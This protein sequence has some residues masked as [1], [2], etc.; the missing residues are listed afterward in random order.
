MRP[1]AGRPIPARRGKFALAALL[2][3]ALATLIGCVP[4]KQAVTTNKGLIEAQPAQP[5]TSRG[6]QYAVHRW[7]PDDSLTFLALY[8]ADD[9]A[10]GETIRAANPDLDL[11]G[12]VAS[13]TEV[14]IPAGI[15]I[16]QVR[17]SVK[18]V[19]RAEPAP[20]P[21]TTPAPKSTSGL[22]E[23]DLGGAVASAGPVLTPSYTS[24]LKTGG[25]H[26]RSAKRPLK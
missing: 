9:K 12:R 22:A 17:R 25:I 3:V 2:L 11:S 23:E 5:A 24:R 13:G 20:P 8:Y 26:K 7:K 21:T 14:L 16:P 1:A 18:I 19:R 10:A 15:I 6:L 4:E